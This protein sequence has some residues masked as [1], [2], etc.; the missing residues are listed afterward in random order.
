MG[1][2]SLYRSIWVIGPNARKVYQLWITKAA[3]SIGDRGRAA[4]G[5]LR[6]PAVVP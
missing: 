1:G 5:S 3:A 6:E 2:Q 4:D